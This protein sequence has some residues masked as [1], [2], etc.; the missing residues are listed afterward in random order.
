MTMEVLGS[1][2]GARVNQ[3]VLGS[4][5]GA[6]VNQQEVLGSESGARVNQYSDLH[7][8]IDG[9][10]GR[11]FSIIVLANNPFVANLTRRSC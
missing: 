10:V 4:E 3:E 8:G 11:F 6:R 1:E 7:S 9:L 5:S 2:S